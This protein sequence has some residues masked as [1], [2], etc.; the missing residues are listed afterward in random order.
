MVKKKVEVG[1]IKEVDGKTLKCVRAN[2]L[3]D[4]IEWVDVGDFITPIFKKE[5]IPCNV[6]LYKKWAEKTSE[7][8]ITIVPVTLVSG[9]RITEDKEG[10]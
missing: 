8:K 10:E 9:K 5:K 4:C 2:N 1:D 6:E 7:R 3:G